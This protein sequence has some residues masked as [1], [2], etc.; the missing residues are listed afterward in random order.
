MLVVVVT[1]Q[2]KVRW[3]A[4]QH[5]YPS[6]WY[7]PKK[8]DTFGGVYQN[9]EQFRKIP[10]LKNKNLNAKTKK[11]PWNKDFS[12]YQPFGHYM[13]PRVGLEPTTTRLTAACSA[14]WAN[15]E[16]MPRIRISSDSWFRQLSPFPGSRPPSIIDVKE[17]NF[18][19]RDG[20]G[21]ILFAIVTGFLEVV[22]SKLNN[23]FHLLILDSL[24][25]IYLSIFLNLTAYSFLCFGQA[26]GLL[27]S[28]S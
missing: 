24:L 11:S 6:I 22:P 3:H 17:L 7:A 20:N 4:H 18:R 5:P 12:L 23:V 27:V 15:E 14:N 9:W 2:K 21:W 10:P 25:F 1:Q 26:L 16:Y 13:A 19:V 28:I 8:L